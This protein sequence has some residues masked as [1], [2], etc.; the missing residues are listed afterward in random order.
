[1]QEIKERPPW[2]SRAIVA[3]LVIAG[4]VAGAFT[5]LRERSQ[6]GGRF[7]PD[8]S[9]I[10]ITEDGKLEVRD[11]RTGELHRLLR[12]D[13][14]AQEFA[15]DPDGVHI[16][17]APD[18]RY[19]YHDATLTK[20]KGRD[21]RVISRVDLVRAFTQPF[22][23]G[24]APVLDDGNLSYVAESFDGKAPFAVLDGPRP[25]CGEA[26]DDASD[27][28]VTRDLRSQ[29]ENYS[30]EPHD[31]VISVPKDLRDFDGVVAAAWLPNERTGDD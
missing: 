30:S 28:Y 29:I 31:A 5:F 22:A 26:G 12:E 20:C 16:T 6:G 19:A 24:E 4:I 25:I 1:M 3:V 18:G 9:F 21:V 27:L 15:N 2:V 10:A 23:A 17:V 8:N 7:H 11:G 14:A 13:L